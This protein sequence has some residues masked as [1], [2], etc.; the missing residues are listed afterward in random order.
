VSASKI[1]KPR[2]PNFTKFSRH[3]ASAVASPPLAAW[4]YVMY[5]RFCGVDDVMIARYRP[6]NGPG[7][8]KSARTK[9][10]SLGAQ[11]RSRCLHYCCVISILL[12]WCDIARHRVG[13]YIGRRRNSTRWFSR[14]S[15]CQ[16]A[17]HASHRELKCA[18]TIGT[19]LVPWAGH[20]QC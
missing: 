6:G 9:R 3:V 15:H 2:F 5:F 20:F 1:K 8:V 14:R 18:D 13:I 12:T 11:G 16:A 10:D 4:R 17:S 7:D 19:V